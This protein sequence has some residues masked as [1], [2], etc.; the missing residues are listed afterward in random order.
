MNKKQKNRYLKIGG[1]KCP[2]CGSDDIFTSV[3]DIDGTR[4]WQNNNCKGCEKEW[5][6]VFALIDV[7]EN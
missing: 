1:I 3:A 2:Y 5:T 6:D 4:A 7:E